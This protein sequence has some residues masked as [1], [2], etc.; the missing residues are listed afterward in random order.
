[1]VK[2]PLLKQ[3]YVHFMK[4]FEAL[5]RMTEVPVSTCDDD[6]PHFHLPRYAVLKDERNTAKLRIVFDR[7]AKT[8]TG[9]SLNDPQYIGASAQDELVS[10]LK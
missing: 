3:Q 4:E 9:I 2:Q 10:I 7:S 6:T 8:S 1:M 5:G